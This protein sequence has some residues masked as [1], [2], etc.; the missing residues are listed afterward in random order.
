[1]A[2]S[3]SERAHYKP[4]LIVGVCSVSFIPSVTVF[5]QNFFCAVSFSEPSHLQV[6]FAYVMAP[7]EHKIVCSPLLRERGL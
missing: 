4:L 3:L 7:L 5:L 1:M 2:L 6:V